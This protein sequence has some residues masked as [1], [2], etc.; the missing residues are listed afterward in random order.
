MQTCG[1][2]TRQSARSSGGSSGCP[3]RGEVDALM[4]QAQKVDEWRDKPVGLGHGRGPARH[5]LILKVLAALRHMAKGLD[6]D[7]LEDVARI[8]ESTLRAFIKQFVKWLSVEMYPLHVKLPDA[9]KLRASLKVYAKLGTPGAYC[10]TDGVH[11][12]WEACPAA[13]RARCV[14][15]EGY[16]TIAFNVSILHSREIIHVS[17]WCAGAVN[18]QTQARHD[19]LF[20]KLR[21]SQADLTDNP[22]LLKFELLDHAGN[23]VGHEGLYAIVDGGY[24]AWRCLQPPLKHAAGDDAARW[25]ERMES[26]RK[27]VEMTFGILKK[28]FRLLRG[29]QDSRDPVHISHVFRACCVLH[30]ILLKHDKL[31]SMGVRSS[32]WVQSKEVLRTRALSLQDVVRD[33][34]RRECVHRLFRQLPLLE[35]YYE[36]NA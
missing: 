23:P 21:H 6:P 14:G 17:E 9:A 27:A 12:E 22:D 24:L 19:K 15:K 5:P 25:S 4:V 16:P 33:P 28:R 29:A 32:D 2:R 20:Q 30:N 26:I 8:S 36:E 31:D 1:T 11:L 35:A 7:D 3:C 34:F 18:D 10:E 13:W